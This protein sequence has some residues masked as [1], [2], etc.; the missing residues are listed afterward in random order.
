MAQ[1]CSVFR[2]AKCSFQRRNTGSFQHVYTI[3]YCTSIGEAMSCLGKQAHRLYSNFVLV[4]ALS[5]DDITGS[6]KL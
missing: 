6:I 5:V 3:V 1:Y 4:T 2:N